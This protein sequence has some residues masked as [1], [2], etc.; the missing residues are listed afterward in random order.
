MIHIVAYVTTRTYWSTN[1]IARFTVLAETT[2]TLMA[3]RSWIKNLRTLCYTLSCLDLS[4]LPLCLMHQLY[5]S[6][7]SPVNHILQSHASWNDNKLPNVIIMSWYVIFFINSSSTYCKTN[8]SLSM[9][10]TVITATISVVWRRSW[11]YLAKCYTLITGANYALNLETK[12]DKLM[13]SPTSAPN[14]WPTSSHQ[15]RDWSPSRQDANLTLNP[16][17]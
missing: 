16:S 5:L 10:L 12:S 15:L 6:L 14:A 3:S 11:K 13:A 7:L 9:N 8:K 4:W 2:L 1:P 17:G